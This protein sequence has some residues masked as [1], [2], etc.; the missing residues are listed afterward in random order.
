[1]YCRESCSSTTR[2][3]L[4]MVVDAYDGIV[5]CRWRTDADLL[6]DDRRVPILWITTAR[7]L[8]YDCYSGILSDYDD[9]SPS[10]DIDYQYMRD[11]SCLHTGLSC[12]DASYEHHWLFL[13]LVTQ[14]EIAPVCAGG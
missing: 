9:Y 4:A 2:N 6:N 10:L 7:G 12:R 1:M 13:D 8:N 14:E 3:D 11:T 5:G